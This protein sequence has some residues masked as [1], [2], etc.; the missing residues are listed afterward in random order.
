MQTRVFDFTAN[1][2]YLL[3][4]ALG[5]PLTIGVAM[6]SALPGE[7]TTSAPAPGRRSF[8]RNLAGGLSGGFLL[9]SAG[10]VALGATG[11]HTYDRYQGN[12]GTTSYAQQGED[13]AL[14]NMCQNLGIENPTYLDIGAY[15]PI[16]ISNTYL[17]YTK[18]CK[19][20]L[21]EPNP[22]RWSRLESVRPRDTTLR[23]GIGFGD[24]PETT[25][26]FYVVGGGSRNS[27]AALST[28]SKEEADAV[29]ARTDGRHFVQ[30]V[31]DMKL[32]N[33][34]HVM[35][36]HFQ[37]APNLVSVDVEGLD[38]DILKTV[39]FA[40]FRP[41]IFCVETVEMG[42]FRFLPGILEFMESKNYAVRGGTFVNTIFVDRRHMS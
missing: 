41:D 6:S 34:N 20:V 36:T 33:V 25:A 38:L 31:I 23:A 15:D 21:V 9:G 7:I 13:L 14:W 8:L 39:D 37:R 16:S 4:K 2:A 40:R 27:G 22:A 28:F 10:G 17:F 12:L 30:E 32:L 18:G 1:A 42:T 29:P 3:G 5:F 35:Q 24:E 26:P 19:G 11:M